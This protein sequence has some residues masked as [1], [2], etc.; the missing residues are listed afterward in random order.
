MKEQFDAVKMEVP[1]A[2]FQKVLQVRGVETYPE[3]GDTCRNQC[4]ILAE[5]LRAEGYEVSFTRDKKT[6]H[7]ALIVTTDGRDFYLDPYLLH[8]DPVDIT[9][10]ADKGPKVV[11]ALP[12][13]NGKF[14]KLVFE[15]TRAGFSVKSTAFSKLTDMNSILWQASYYNKKRRPQAFSNKDGRPS[16]TPKR[17]FNLNV[18]L[19]SGEVLKLRWM[20]ANGLREFD[21][22]PIGGTKENSRFNHDPDKFHVQMDRLISRLGTTQ[23]R[24]IAS[25]QAATDLYHGGDPETVQEQ[26]RNTA[27]RVLAET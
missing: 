22:G 9:D 26:M 4:I 17:L 21:V 14:T 6:Y 23:N 11:D 24:L 5:K 7:Q 27:S 12:L 3:L 25:L 10:L 15:A 13:I 8:L 20:I 19:E 16:F 18:P 1:F 2:D